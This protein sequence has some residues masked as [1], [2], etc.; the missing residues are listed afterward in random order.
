MRSG[1]VRA[2]RT[3][4]DSHGG[5]GNSLIIDHC[6][7]YSTLYA[8]LHEIKVKVGQRVSRGDIIGTVGNTG[9]STGP[10]LHLE[11]RIGN[12]H[13]FI[14][15]GNGTAINMMQFFPENVLTR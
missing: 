3:V 10:H 12:S 7:V 5:Y 6:E 11:L 2:I 4:D 9:R 15:G 8:H 14:N 13:Y 1:V